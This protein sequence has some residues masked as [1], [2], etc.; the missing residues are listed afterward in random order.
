MLREKCFKFSPIILMKFE[1]PIQF[2]ESNIYAFDILSLSF[3][4]SLFQV[5][6]ANFVC[7]P[8]P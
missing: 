7:T 8:L 5:K 2:D 6:G 1:C 4:V 3:R